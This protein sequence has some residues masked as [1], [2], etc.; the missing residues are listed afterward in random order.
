VIFFGLLPSGYPRAFEVSL[1]ELAG[2]VLIVAVLAV[3]L[4]RPRRAAVPSGRPAATVLSGRPTPD[5]ADGSQ[6]DA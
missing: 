2:L 5:E 6:S 3:V 1:A 4:P